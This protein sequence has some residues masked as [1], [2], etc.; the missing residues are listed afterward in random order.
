MHLWLYNAP[1]SISAGHLSLCY[2]Q[3]GFY[4]ILLPERQRLASQSAMVW[5]V[6]YPRTV[7]R[8]CC[9]C[10]RLTG[11]PKK[12]MQLPHPYAL[13][14]IK[15]LEW[16]MKFLKKWIALLSEASYT[17]YVIKKRIEEIKLKKRSRNALKN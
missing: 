5:G 11:Y 1:H 15:P 16:M 7:L 14:Q 3:C 13:G 6:F 17:I 9:R 10:E 8:Y 4:G 12:F 2:S